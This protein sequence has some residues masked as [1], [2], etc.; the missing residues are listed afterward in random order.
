MKS[1][2]FYEIFISCNPGGARDFIEKLCRLYVKPKN[3]S[4]YN[5]E[6][7]DFQNIYKA[8]GYQEYFSNQVTF[9]FKT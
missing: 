1:L 3:A 8:K 9:N 5:L 7:S 6:F 2:P 4:L